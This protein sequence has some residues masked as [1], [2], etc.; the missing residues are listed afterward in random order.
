M[1]IRRRTCSMSSK[2][3]VTPSTARLLQSSTRCAPPRSA[4]TADATVST[5]TSSS[6]GGGLT[7]LV[8]GGAAGQRS[9]KIG[10]AGERSRVGQVQAGPNHYAER[11]QHEHVGDARKRRQTV[12]EEARTSRPPM[13]PKMSAVD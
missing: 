9:E 12:R 13:S 11:H 7:L 10:S 3:G 6:T 5:H 4:A 1:E 2:L 8:S